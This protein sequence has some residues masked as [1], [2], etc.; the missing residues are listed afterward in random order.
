MNEL[1]MIMMN[2]DSFATQLIDTL[3]GYRDPSV[4]PHAVLYSA[5]LN[6]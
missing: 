6:K 2:G 1:M 3:Y 4:E 5:E